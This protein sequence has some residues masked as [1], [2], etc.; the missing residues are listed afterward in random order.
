MQADRKTLR[1]AQI[2]RDRRN[3]DPHAAAVVA[4]CMWGERYS[5]QNGGSMD[6]WDALTP[7]EK[8][9]CSEIAKK[10]R[11]ARPYTGETR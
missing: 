11:K 4:M 3:L 8:R 7:S 1:D 6:F 9:L 5:K 2:A 10:C